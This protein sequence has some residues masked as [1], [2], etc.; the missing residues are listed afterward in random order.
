MEDLVTANDI[1]VKN[2]KHVSCFYQVIHNW[3][4][5]RMRNAVGTYAAGECLAAHVFT[6][7]LSSPKRNPGMRER[8]TTC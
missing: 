5:G 4:F 6:A 1:Y 2:R 3:K 7:F 8:K